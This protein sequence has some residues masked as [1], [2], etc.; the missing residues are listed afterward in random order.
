VIFDEAAGRRISEAD[1]EKLQLLHGVILGCT[2][3]FKGYEPDDYE[4]LV[5]VRERPREL[6]E[7][8]LQFVSWLLGLRTVSTG[9]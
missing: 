7:R 6:D 1:E 4:E 3:E 9:D 5:D 8:N 2:I